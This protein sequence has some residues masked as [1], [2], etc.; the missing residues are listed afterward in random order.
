MAV[1]D[2]QIVAWLKEEGVKTTVQIRDFVKEHDPDKRKSYTPGF[3]L[4]NVYKRMV[5]LEK[6]GLVQIAHQDHRHGNYWSVVE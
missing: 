4:G 3:Y 6:K 5:R 1:T 2:E